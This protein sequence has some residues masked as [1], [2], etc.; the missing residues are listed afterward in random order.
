MIQGGT[1]AIDARCK[2]LEKPMVFKD[3]LLFLAEINLLFAINLMHLKSFS[4]TKV[5]IIG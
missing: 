1:L 4:V 3:F 5:S 2:I